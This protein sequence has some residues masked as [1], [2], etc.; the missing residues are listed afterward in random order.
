M[1]TLS[2][3][4]HKILTYTFALLL[5][6]LAVDTLVQLYPLLSTQAMYNS[7]PGASPYTLVLRETSHQPDGSSVVTQESTWAVRGDG[8][9]ARR[10]TQLGA[11]LG[12]QRD[13]QFANGEEV[14]INELTSIKSSTSVAGVNPALWQR[15]YRSNCVN[16]LAGTPFS[17]T[18]EKLVGEEMVDGYRTAKVVSRNKTAW[19]ALEHGCAL[20]RDR[21]EWGNNGVSEHRLVSLT[22]GEPDASLFHVPAEAKEAPPSVRLLSSEKDAGSRCD[23][24]CREILRRMDLKYSANRH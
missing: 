7:P 16:S 5:A 17:S 19:Y 23:A 14:V 9:L 15:D 11:R 2:K 6:G 1:F 8:S 10:F 18:S 12:A 3:R 4:S 20:V 22:P 24:N 13:L 21:A